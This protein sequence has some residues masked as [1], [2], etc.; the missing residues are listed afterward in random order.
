MN[1]INEL[2]NKEIDGVLTERERLKLESLLATDPDGRTLRGDLQALVQRCAESNRVEPPPTL[3]PAVRRAIEALHAPARRP[4]R[5]TEP[6]FHFFSP[7]RD[8]R[9]VYAFLGGI[10]LGAVSLALVMSSVQ[11]NAINDQ[12][13]LG[14][15]ILRNSDESVWTPHL[16]VTPSARGKIEVFNEKTLEA[17]V[18][19]LNSRSP[20]E[21]RLEIRFGERTVRFISQPENA[22]ATME[23][24]PG[25]LVVRGNQVSELRLV[26]ERPPSVEQPVEVSLFEGDTPTYKQNLFGRG[27]ETQE[28]QP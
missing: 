15:M 14:S 1:K 10:A 7:L 27:A 13:A 12:D 21:A 2:L 24:R 4:R 28:L 19:Q 5:V 17:M 26:F 9:L 11:R 3:Q 8:L 25:E 23:L 16:I 20:S 22:H 6:L 18:V